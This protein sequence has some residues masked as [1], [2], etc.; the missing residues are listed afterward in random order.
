MFTN[1]MYIYNLTI[2][3]LQFDFSVVDE[4]GGACH[5]NVVVSLAPLDGKCAAVHHDRALPSGL[6]CQGGGDRRSTSTRT[7]S[8][9]NAAATFPD[10]SADSPVVLNTGELNVAT[11]RK[12]RMLFQDPSCLTYLVYIVCK[13]YV[14]GVSHRDERTLTHIHAS[15]ANK[16]RFILE[17]RF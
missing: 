13:D 5:V 6:A 15:R 3:N 7:A 12:S 14:V 1:A 17:D 4:G 8:L 11:L 16:Q 10:A 2:Y 9:S